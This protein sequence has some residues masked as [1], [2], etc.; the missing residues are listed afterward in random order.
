[1]VAPRGA[2]SPTNPEAKPRA[3]DAWQLSPLAWNRSSVKAKER[4]SYARSVDDSHQAVEGKAAGMSRKTTIEC[5]AEARRE[6]EEAVL[7]ARPEG[8]VERLERPTARLELA[9]C[10]ALKK[11]Q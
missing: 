4:G 3:H 1:M 6:N 5:A 10:R 11:R 2:A 8:T 9:Q 7:A